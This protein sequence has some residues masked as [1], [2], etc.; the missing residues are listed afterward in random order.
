M[1]GVARTLPETWPVRIDLQVLALK[2]LGT[3]FFALGAVG[4]LV[5]LLPT[6]IFWIVAASCYAKSAPELAE[7]LF[8]HPRIGPVLRDWVEHR[9]MS[10]N[11]KLFAIG[12]MSGNF[13][14]AA[15]VADLA[16]GPLIA[17]AALFLAISTYVATRPAL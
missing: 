8:A 7:R 13:A 9:A 16:G 5:P 3:M 17:T 14:A 6:T 12:G 15:W 11:A 2:A 1:S 10:R 4:L